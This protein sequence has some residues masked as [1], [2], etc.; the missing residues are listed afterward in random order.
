VQLRFDTYT[1]TVGSYAPPGPPT[2]SNAG[3]I[4]AHVRALGPDHNPQG[5]GTLPQSRRRCSCPAS[6]SAWWASVGGS[7]AF[8][9][10]TRGTTYTVKAS[11]AFYKNG[12]VNSSGSFPDRT[13]TP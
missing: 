6:A 7:S 3:S 10:M 2:A 8:T 9:D 4:S 12:V 11:V 5:G 13:I 1:V